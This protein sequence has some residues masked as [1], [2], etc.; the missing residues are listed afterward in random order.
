MRNNGCDSIWLGTQPGYPKQKVAAGLK[1]HGPKRKLI[2]SRIGY[3]GKP[4]H[5]TNDLHGGLEAIC[6]VSNHG[7]AWGG[8]KRLAK[9]RLGS[10][11]NI[12]SKGKWMEQS[13]RLAHKKHIKISTTEGSSFTGLAD[14]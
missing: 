1:T 7:A 11:L 8:D 13:K 10:S 2:Y 3:R 12:M 4:M 14:T 9:A 6:A 5:I